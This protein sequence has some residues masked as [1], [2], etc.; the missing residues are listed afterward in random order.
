M[1]C[2]QLHVQSRG[3]FWVLSTVYLMH[4]A[5]PLFD[6]TKRP[7]QAAFNLVIQR[8]RIAGGTLTI[9]IDS[10][11]RLVKCS[12]REAMH[13][14]IRLRYGAMRKCLTMR[15]SDSLERE[16]WLVGI[17]AAMGASRGSVEGEPISSTARTVSEHSSESSAYSVDEQSHYLISS[18]NEPQTPPSAMENGMPITPKVGQS[19]TSETREIAPNDH[20]TVFL[21]LPASV[22]SGDIPAIDM[23]STPAARTLGLHSIDAIKRLADGY[24]NL[25]L[26][27]TQVAAETRQFCAQ[28]SSLQP[29]HLAPQS[30][31]IHCSA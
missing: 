28:I 11:V 17:I 9:P 15:A 14:T 29:P 1:T 2:G 22:D 4:V 25:A 21:P 19:V 24:D 20:D 6:S 5:L 13:N 12:G 7:A 18:F 10:T 3:I 27:W 30:C 16:K 31:T 8:S 23:T 26:K